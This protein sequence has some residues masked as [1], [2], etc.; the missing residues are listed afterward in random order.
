MTHSTKTGNAAVG[1]V[2]M[3]CVKFSPEFQDGVF[4]GTIQAAAQPSGGQE[5]QD[6]AGA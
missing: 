1:T 4:V 3:S 2:L 5:A 6:P